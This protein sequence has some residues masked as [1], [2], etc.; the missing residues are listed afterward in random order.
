MLLNILGL[1]Y[2]LD[3]DPVHKVIFFGDRNTMS[4][5]KVSIN[6]LSDLEDDRTL[7]FNNAS[8]WDIS[9][10]WIN[11]YLYWSDDV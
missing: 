5:W 10:D 9:Y 3:F 7:L 2:A 6:R 4:I 1:I 8:V 11:E